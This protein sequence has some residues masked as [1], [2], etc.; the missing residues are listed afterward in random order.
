[1]GSRGVWGFF[2]RRQ[3]A[4]RES[5]AE[6]FLAGGFDFFPVISPRPE[7]DTCFHCGLPRGLWK[8]ATGQNCVYA[9]HAFCC[10]GCRDGGICECR[11]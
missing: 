7:N 1:V 9:G 11:R 6:T 8:D 2:S 3:S 5:D 4:A 10:E